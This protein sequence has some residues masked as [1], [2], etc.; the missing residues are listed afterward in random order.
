VPQLLEQ[1]ENYFSNKK[2]DLM[3]YLTGIRK[4]A[5]SKQ[6]YY[7]AINKLNQTLLPDYEDTLYRWIYGESLPQTPTNIVERITMKV[8]SISNT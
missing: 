7:R 8:S 2:I 6:N 1:Y 3:N 5:E 4:L